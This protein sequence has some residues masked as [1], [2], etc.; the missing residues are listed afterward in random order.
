MGEWINKIWY[1]HIIEYFS[2]FKK[3]I[4][5]YVT[6][7]INFEDIMPSKISH[8]LKDK[9]CVIPLAQGT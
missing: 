3:E 8:S 1:I 4:L 6:T 2:V 7:W 9:Y 5:T